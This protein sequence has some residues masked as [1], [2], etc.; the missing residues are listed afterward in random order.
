MT[1]EPKIPTFDEEACRIY[2]ACGG[3]MPVKSGAL[4]AIKTELKAAW[5]LG[6]M[7][8]LKRQVEQDKNP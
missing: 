7:A 8:V 3:P 5:L 2:L 6:G 1:D 4:V